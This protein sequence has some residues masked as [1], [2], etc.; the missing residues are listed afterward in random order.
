MTAMWN[1]LFGYE[2]LADDAVFAD[3]GGDSLIM[4]QLARRLRERLGVAVPIR[5]LMAARTLG[6]QIAVVEGVLAERPAGPEQPA[7]LTSTGG[8]R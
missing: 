7:F 5:E 2:D 6:G 4:V 3:L 8:R 1:E